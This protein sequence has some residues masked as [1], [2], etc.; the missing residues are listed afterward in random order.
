IKDVAKRPINKKV[1]F[2]EATLIIPENTKINEKLGNLIDQETGYGLQIIFT[3]EK[4]STCAKK[5]IRNGL[6]YGIIYNDNITEL[7]LIGQ[8]IEKVNGF[9]NICN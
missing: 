9:V 5:K 2:E 6:S 4:S 7:R 3:N 8:R 1:Q